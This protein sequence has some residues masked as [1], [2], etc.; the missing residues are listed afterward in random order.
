MQLK[1]NKTIVKIQDSVYH[2]EEGMG[3]NY[4]ERGSRFV[5]CWQY[6]D[7]CCLYVGFSL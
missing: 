3:H 7:Q 4:R 6:L 1:E 5:E 2:W